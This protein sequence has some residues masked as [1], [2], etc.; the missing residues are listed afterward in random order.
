M[1]RYSVSSEWAG[2]ASVFSVILRYLTAIFLTATLATSIDAAFEVKPSGAR[3]GDL[4]DTYTAHVK[5]VEGLFWNPGAVAWTEG[6]ELF[7]GFE[8]PW[9]MAVLDTHSGAVSLNLGRG[10]LGLHR[11]WVRALPGTA[12][13]RDGRAPSGG[14]VRTGCDVAES[15][16]NG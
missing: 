16:S 2:W 9:G 1:N 14:K 3:A 10:A 4:G 11:L 8:R 13:R 7:A 12:D 5:G 6:V 15:G